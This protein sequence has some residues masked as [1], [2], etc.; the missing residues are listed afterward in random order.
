MDDWNEGEHA[1]NIRKE[2]DAAWNKLSQTAKN[3]NI[4]SENRSA[5]MWKLES[6]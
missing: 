3:K 1:P 2:V 5:R 6:W 4:K